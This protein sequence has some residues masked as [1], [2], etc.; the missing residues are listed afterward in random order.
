MNTHVVGWLRVERYSR[1]NCRSAEA[2]GGAVGQCSL[3]SR[4]V[5]GVET[6]DMANTAPPTSSSSG[7]T[8]NAS[9]GSEGSS[10]A[11]AAPL[12]SRL[13]AW[14]GDEGWVCQTCKH[15]FGRLAVHASQEELL[16]THEEGKRHRR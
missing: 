8:S 10:T 14:S 7:G 15:V 6:A 16:K 1:H 9:E 11:A 4:G 12:M 3:L 13:A 2:L 5:A